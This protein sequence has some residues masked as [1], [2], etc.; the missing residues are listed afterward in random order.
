MIFEPTNFEWKAFLLE[1]NT[2][3][4]FT[5]Q[6]S[7][8][9]VII[10]AQQSSPSDKKKI[11]MLSL[12]IISVLEIENNETRFISGEGINHLFPGFLSS[13]LLVNYEKN[14]YFSFLHDCFHSINLVNVEDNVSA[15][16]TQSQLVVKQRAFVSA[17]NSRLHDNVYT[18]LS[19]PWLISYDPI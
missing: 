9:L 14:H 13:T 17:C 11:S 8:V 15:V 2:T 10:H 12:L 19:I 18:L 16:L 5:L 1:E 3:F 4:C 7:G 6:L